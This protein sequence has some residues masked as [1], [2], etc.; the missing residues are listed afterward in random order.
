MDIPT[1]LGA[2]L[3]YRSVWYNIECKTPHVQLQASKLHVYDK[4]DFLLL[5][6]VLCD[7]FYTGNVIFR[8]L[9]TTKRCVGKFR[10]DSNIVYRDLFILQISK[11]TFGRDHIQ[12]FCYTEV[13]LRAPETAILSDR[14][15]H[16]YYGRYREN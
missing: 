3:H 14:S 2:G 7:L 16:Q 13:Q 5:A 10:H 6:R 8:K 4:H 15:E 12:T 11:A 9:H 1:F